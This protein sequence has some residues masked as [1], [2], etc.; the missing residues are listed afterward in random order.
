MEQPAAS[1]ASY[2][3]GSLL[4]NGSRNNGYHHDDEEPLTG[5]VV[6]YGVGHST[7]ATSVLA[8]TTAEMGPHIIENRKYRS[9]SATSSPYISNYRVPA[10]Q[11]ASA[12]RHHYPNKG[13]HNNG[14]AG[15]A[16]PGYAM[17]SGP[18]QYQVNNNVAK[19]SV[20]RSLG[21]LLENENDGLD[22]RI[23]MIDHK[24]SGGRGL[25]RYRGR[26]ERS[27]HNFKKSSVELTTDY[28]ESSSET[29]MEETDGV[30]VNVSAASG[31]KI[32]D[33]S[34]FTAIYDYDAK[35]EDELTLRRGNTVTV[36]SKDPSISGDQGWW[37]GKV[38][39]QVGIF[40]SN[41]VVQD[42]ERISDP[43]LINY[44]ELELQEVIGAGGF[45]KVYRGTWG[46]Q[47]VAVKAA[48]HDTGEDIHVT[49]QNVRK[50]AMLFWMLK[51]KNIV[52]LLG[53]CLTPPNLCLVMEYARGGS[54]SR[55]L[56][57]RKICP[58]TLINWAVQI[59]EGMNYLHSISIIHRDLKSSNGK[60]YFLNY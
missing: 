34:I 8:A 47:E 46:S 44:R 10:S 52:A 25:S 38:G 24:E 56:S 42:L 13:H 14:V 60:F 50:E 41:F 19:S 21:H 58:S 32:N 7:G 12:S 31:M 37:V 16:K 53:L 55:V 54:L 57:G 15:G 22:P 30:D 1:P 23:S 9:Y 20:H 28:G 43:P 11:L 33:G 59:A 51:H 29:I 49:I 17:P 5:P 36:F 2:L 48:L 35:M 26:L 45:G 39:S 4:A 6:N 18:S 40:P 27:P 3:V